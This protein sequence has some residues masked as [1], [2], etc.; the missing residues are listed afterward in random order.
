MKNFYSFKS[1]KILTANIAKLLATLALVITFIT[2][3]AQYCTTNLHTYPYV[4]GGYCSLDKSID[5]VAIIGTTLVNNAIG[6]GDSTTGY[7]S[8]SVSANLTQGATYVLYLNALCEG[9]ASAWIDY[10]KNNTFDSTEWINLGRNTFH[11]ANVSFTVPTTATIG[12]TTMRIRTLLC[13]NPTNTAN[14]A[15]TNFSSGGETEDYVIN[16][17]APTSIAKQINTVN[18]KAY[19]NPTT[20]LL[21]IALPTN[22]VASYQV[23]NS[24][25]QLVIN[26]TFI[27]NKI[28]LSA[29]QNGTY[30]LRVITSNGVS[31][32]RIV[33]Q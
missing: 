1:R 11:S 21:T 28:D 3:N 19:P 4:H 10:N 27:D 5:S 20:G 17:V 13:C 8:Y 26:G 32:Q 18:I 24:I 25:G 23:F 9:D 15:C 31:T 6:L 7:S 2:A 30:T 22:E 14:D 12:N 16:I 33:K 29:Y